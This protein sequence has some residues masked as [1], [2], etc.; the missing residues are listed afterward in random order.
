MALPADAPGLASLDLFVSVVQLGSLSAAAS[1]H[2]ISQPSASARIRQLERQLGLELLT[3]GP[4]G[5]VPTSAGRMVAEWAQRVLDPL[6]D[7]LRS[8]AALRA[9]N[10]TNVRVAASYTIAEHLLPRWLSAL[11]R[12][13]PDVDVELLVVN[14]AGVLDQVRAGDVEL[15]FIEGAGPVQGLQTRVVAHDD[16]VVVVDPTHGGLVAAGPSRRSSSLRLRWSPGRPVR[17]PA[18]PCPVPWPIAPWPRPNQ[19][20]N[21]PRP[22]RC[23]IR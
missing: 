14:T 1:A 7:L 11:R 22:P 10:E 18:T 15:G 12:V 23:E 2:G 5:S 19:R 21:W 8:T 6:D 17:V 16:L 13:H 9:G 4:N 3:R 20:W